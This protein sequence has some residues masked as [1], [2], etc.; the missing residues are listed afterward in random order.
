MSEPIRAS[1]IAH[2]SYAAAGGAALAAD[3]LLHGLA[4]SEVRARP[5]ETGR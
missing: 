3:H 4:L 2:W 5:Q 1:E